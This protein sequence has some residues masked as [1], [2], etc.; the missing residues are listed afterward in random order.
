MFIVLLV[1]SIEVEGNRF[2]IHGQHQDEQE[3]LSS[4][5]S[6]GG[7]CPDFDSNA[8]SILDSVVFVNM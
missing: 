2:K 3:N 7:L 8:M 5:R 4:S 6:N 1:Y